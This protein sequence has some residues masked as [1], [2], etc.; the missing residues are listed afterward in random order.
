[1]PTPYRPAVHSILVDFGVVL[2]V[3]VTGVKQSQLLVQRLGLEFDNIKKILRK[4]TE[5]NKI[6]RK[7]PEIQKILRKCL[8]IRKIL[9]K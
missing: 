9:R 5:I 6:L 1:M 7:L 3:L 4:L 8:E 2:V